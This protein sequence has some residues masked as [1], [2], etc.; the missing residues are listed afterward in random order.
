MTKKDLKE[1]MLQVINSS[2]DTHKDEWYITDRT[3]VKVGIEALA[4]LLNINLDT[5]DE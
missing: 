5:V 1:K 2:D 3:A 4:D